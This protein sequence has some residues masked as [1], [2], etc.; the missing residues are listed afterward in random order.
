MSVFVPAPNVDLLDPLSLLLPMDPTSSVVSCRVVVGVEPVLNG[1]QTTSGV[2]DDYSS[3]E[4][5]FPLPLE[6][7]FSVVRVLLFDRLLSAKN[8]AAFCGILASVSKGWH[9]SADYCLCMHLLILLVVRLRL[10]FTPHPSFGPS[11]PSTG[12]CQCIG[13][14]LCSTAASLA[15]WT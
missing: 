13:W 5:K 6:L 3:A 10:V 1:L 7:W 9:V 14:T 11:S 15:T 12:I 4:F 8:S 2:P